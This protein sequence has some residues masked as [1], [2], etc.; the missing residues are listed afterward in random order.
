MPVRSHQCGYQARKPTS[1]LL[2]RRAGSCAA[3]RPIW[4]G[5]V[6][7]LLAMLVLVGCAADPP[8]IP[9]TPLTNVDR[10]TSVRTL[11]GKRVGD[12][13]AAPVV[14]FSPYID[15]QDVYAASS[16]GVVMRLD[17]PSGSTRWRK[18]LKL[19]LTSG[20]G[21][22][23][24]AVYVGSRNGLIVALSKSDGAELWRSTMST[25]VLAP[26]VG[27]Q[28]R[29][30][31]RGADGRV[32]A[33]DAGDGSELWSRTF[34]PPAL[35]LNGYSQPQLVGNGILLG[36]DDGKV[37]ALANDSG[38]LLWQSVLVYATGRSEIE[39]LVDID[40]NLL[41][42]DAYIYAASYQG[43]LARLEPVRGQ[44]TW[45]VDFSSV[46]GM[47]QNSDAVFAVDADDELVALSK[48]DGRELWRLEALRGRRLTRPVVTGNSLVVADLEGFVHVVDV[49][50]GGLKGR[51][52]PGDEAVKGSL[53]ST[54]DRV[55]LQDSDARLRALQIN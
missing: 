29:V 54:G 19:A 30:I 17:A 44:I 37:A 20:V 2:L 48:Q 31:V 35:T 49:A 47:A 51:A 34:A 52:R 41:V 21:G 45:A 42:D 55:Y 23:E 14:R 27:G 8:R 33:L 28:G 39:R 38:N 4:K 40:A 25:E 26:V 22:T 1:Q 50:T 9:P 36:L 16:D 11:W 32:A 13:D 46:V 10:S 5:G 7:G 15:G 3:R 6:L 43:K 12:E 18:Q 53:I 24:E